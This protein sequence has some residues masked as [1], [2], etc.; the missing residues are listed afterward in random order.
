VTSQGL[1]RARRAW[2]RVR[3]GQPR[4]LNWKRSATSALFALA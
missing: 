1:R 3:S 2:A 4:R